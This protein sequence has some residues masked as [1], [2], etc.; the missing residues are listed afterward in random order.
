V[1]N[2]VR[3]A[4]TAVGTTTMINTCQKRSPRC[5]SCWECSPPLLEL[6][7]VMPYGMWPPW[8]I[9]AKEEQAEPE[10]CRQHPPPRGHHRSGW[11]AMV[12]SLAASLSVTHAPKQWPDG[13][14]RDRARFGSSCSGCPD[15]LVMITGYDHRL[16]G[17]CWSS[18]RSSLALLWWAFM[19]DCVRPWLLLEARPGRGTS[20]KGR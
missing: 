2:R 3:S 13:P 15:H 20:A 1:T 6:L 10:Q 14:D 17:A 5:S 19:I 11:P 7:S 4:L 18:A 12:R 16:A 8:A 9:S